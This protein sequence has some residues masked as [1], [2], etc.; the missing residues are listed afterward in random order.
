MSP[1]LNQAVVTN[2]GGAYPGT[3]TALRAADGE[4]VIVYLP[5]GTSN[6]TADL[7]KI[8]GGSAKG[9]W[10]DPRTGASTLVG[11]Y[12]TTSGNRTFTLPDG[13]DWV[14]MLDDASKNL[15]APGTTTY[16]KQ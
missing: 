15:A 14:L 8:S 7:S 1:D 11:R 10:Y 12:P 5:G 4:T 6:P 3:I 13:N 2:G 9:W 16:G